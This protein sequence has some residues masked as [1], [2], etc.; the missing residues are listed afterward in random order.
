MSDCKGILFAV[1]GTTCP[2]AKV[3]FERIELAASRRFPEVALR[4]AFTSAPIRRKLTAQGIEA[5][6][7]EEALELMKKEGLSQVAVISLHL[8]DG[9]EFGE[10]V[11]T[12]AAFGRHPGNRMKVALGHALMACEA[13]WVQAL[14]SILKELPG[15]PGPRDRVILVAHGSTDS[16]AEKTL[17]AAVQGCRRVD[18][19]L[20]L[21]MILGKP[22]C[23]EVVRECLDN[24]VKKVWL[25]P[26][27]VVAGFTARDEISGAGEHSWATALIR[28][29]IA[30]V[31]V[32]KGLGETSG[33][34]DIWL[35]QAGG[36]LRDN[37]ER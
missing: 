13:D 5:N 6:S 27:M 12:V 10:L 37:H 4:W 16:H 36:L 32:T 25:I 24:E 8:T 2:D 29:G 14:S 18:P 19:R 17:Q 20:I 15:K 7:P 34:V 22:G 1:P 28:A 11:E 31:S 26:C 9:L 3:A 23:D 35:E 30:V 21:G 33:V